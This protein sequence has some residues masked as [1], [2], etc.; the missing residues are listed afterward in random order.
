GSDQDSLVFNGSAAAE[1]FN[2]SANGSRLSLTRNLGSIKMDVGSIESVDLNALG[3][4]DTVTIDPLA[5]TSV[6][7]VN[8][9]LGVNSAGDAAVDSVIVNGTAGVDVVQAAA[10]NGQVVVTGAG[11]QVEIANPEAA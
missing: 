5:G 8:V 9:G 6:T 1:I 10:V 2:L 7:G 11:P 4:T 3:G